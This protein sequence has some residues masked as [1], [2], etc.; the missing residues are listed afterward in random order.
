MD[1]AVYMLSSSPFDIVLR[2]YDTTKY[3]ALRFP[4]QP[5][6][7]EGSDDQG[8]RHTIPS[9]TWQ[10]LFGQTLKINPHGTT[11]LAEGLIVLICFYSADGSDQH[12][13]SKSDADQ[14]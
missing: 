13:Q 3:L 4:C 7:T 5:R 9:R 8:S 6:D 2:G 14:L 10:G 1:Q 12:E 11:S